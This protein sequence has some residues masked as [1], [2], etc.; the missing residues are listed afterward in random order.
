MAKDNHD[1]TLKTVPAK[2][3]NSL[4]I[5]PAIRALLRT[6]IVTGLIIVIPIWV[7]WVVVKF[8]FDIMKSLTYPLTDRIAKGLLERNKELEL[9]PETVYM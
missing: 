9:V 6:R 7:T 5:W 4:G 8:V 3:T 1:S 2:A